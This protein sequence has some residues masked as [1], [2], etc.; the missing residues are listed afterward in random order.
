MNSTLI[1]K[2]VNKNMKS[3]ILPS[4]IFLFQYLKEA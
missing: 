2:N 1:L 4:K 3:Q